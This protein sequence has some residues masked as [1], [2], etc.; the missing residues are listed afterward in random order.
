[1]EAAYRDI[2]ET[3]YTRRP[4]PSFPNLE[5]EY[6]PLFL[7]P[8]GPDELFVRQAIDEADAGLFQSR[9]RKL[10]ADAKY[11]LLLNFMQMVFAPV[12]LRGGGVTAELTS[13]LVADIDLVINEAARQQ[14]IRERDSESSGL[15]PEPSDVTGHAVLEAVATNWGN[16]RLS[17]F[18]IWGED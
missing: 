5:R 13:S 18:R 16:L 9:R 12:R 4:S 17:S 15:A 8:F 3:M 7:Y 6:L 10:R 1:M 11:F 14:E 2:F